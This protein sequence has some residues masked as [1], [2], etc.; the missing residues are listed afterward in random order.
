MSLV[1]DATTYTAPE[2]ARRQEAPDELPTGNSSKVT[3]AP[4]Q[5][6]LDNPEYFTVDYCARYTC[7]CTQPYT[8]DPTGNLRYGYFDIVERHLI[9][10]LSVDPAH[11]VYLSTM[12]YEC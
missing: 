10:F 1:K 6:Y 7:K 12:L 3:A 8:T 9:R 11:P 4:L 2:R 5:G